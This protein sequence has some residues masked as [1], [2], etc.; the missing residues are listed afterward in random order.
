MTQPG[1]YADPAGVPGFRWWDGRAW[2]AHTHPPAAPQP[3]AMPHPAVAHP[4]AAPQQPAAAYPPAA[5][6]AP[7][8]P[9]AVAQYPPQAP[10]SSMMDERVVN[11]QAGKHQV[12]ADPQ[13]ISYGGKTLQL[14]AVDWVCYFVER[15]K[16]VNHTIIGSRKSSLGTY[17]HFQIGHHPYFKG[18]FIEIN[19]SKWR[20]HD[21]N[22]VWEALV[23]HS[24]RFVEP[25]LIAQITAQLRAGQTVALGPLTLDPSGSRPPRD[26]SPGG[27]CPGPPST[28][29]RSSSSR[30]RRRHCGYRRRT[31]TWDSSRR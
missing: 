25:R 22:P 6:A 20:D 1:W 5:P 29:A 24:R 23:A 10:A 21:T 11:A 18:E 15:P 3:P 16:M 26:G 13:I 17:F 4:P 27:N 12:Y 7:L 9:T 8:Q 2:T 28:T 19:I 30:G 14:A 31:G